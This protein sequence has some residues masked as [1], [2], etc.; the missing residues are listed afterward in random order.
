MRK[1][2]AKDLQAC[3]D[4]I[5]KATSISKGAKDPDICKH[6]A[7]RL[8]YDIFDN[9]VGKINDPGQFSKYDKSIK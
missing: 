3:Q 4:Q 6:M 5:A 1:V 9:T 7:N 8:L 2:I